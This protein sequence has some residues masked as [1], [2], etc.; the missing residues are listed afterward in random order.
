MFRLVPSYELAP[1]HFRE[2]P[3][4]AVHTRPDEI[5]R[6]VGWGVDRGALMAELGRAL[7]TGDDY[8]YPVLDPDPLPERQMLFIRASFTSPEGLA[9]QGYLMGADPDCIGL[10]AGEE[11]VLFNRRLP[12]LA[13]RSLRSLRKS[14]PDL[15]GALFPLEYSSAFRSGAGQPIRGR[16]ELPGPGS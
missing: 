7:E 2:H 9:W 16:F 5:E 3:V 15:E 6:I 12:A 4:W 8:V 10:F 11:V 1:R 14:R 13:T